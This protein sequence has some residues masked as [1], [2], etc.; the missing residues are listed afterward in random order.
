MVAEAMFGT[1]TEPGKQWQK[2]R[3]A[4]LKD[5]QVKSVIANIA[6]WN[7]KTEQ[8]RETQRT[9]VN[10]F[11]DNA[12]RMRYKTYLEKGLHIGSGVVEA[13]C[14]HVVAQR[15]DQ[16]GMHWNPD[17]ADAILALRANLRSTNQTDLRP[18]LAIAA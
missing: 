1:G 14:K 16:A 18:H 15:L 17:N 12:E 5:N 7:P 10:Y 8:D 9:Q 6:S 4:E 2:D 3:Q 13:S 11:T